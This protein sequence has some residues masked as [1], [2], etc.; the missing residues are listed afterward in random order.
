MANA[1]MPE[2]EANY[3]LIVI[4]A[5]P[6]GY[7][8][9]IRAAQQGK[10]VA[11]VEEAQ[12]GG[13]CLNWGCIPT[14]A[15]LKSAELYQKMQKAA[16]FGI[17]VSALSPDI[18][19]MVTRSKQVSEKLTAGIKHLMKKNRIT[20]LVG[21][22]KLHSSTEI[23]VQVEVQN[24]QHH[25]LYSANHVILA[26]G[27]SARHLPGIPPDGKHIWSYREALRQSRIPES[28]VVIGSGAIGIEFANFYHA[29]GTDVTVVE[30]MSQ[31]MP[32][33]DTEIA[34]LAMKTMQ[35]RGIKFCLNSKVGSVKTD[36]DANDI[37][38]NITN[39][40][41]EHKQLQAQHLLSA[42]GVSPNTDDLGLEQ[43]GIALDHKGFIAT[44]EFC[45]TNVAN[46]FAIGDV[47][48]A[49]CL[50]HKAS[51]EGLLVADLICGKPVHPIEKHAIPGCIYS[52]PQ[53]ASIGLTQAEAE[54]QSLPIK[55][56]RFS[57]AGNGK[58]I[59]QGES[60]G[61]VKVIFHQQTGELLGAH[62]VGSEVT[63]MLQGFA[64]GKTLETTEEQLMQTIFPH[65]TM[66]EMMHESVLDAFDQ[67]I[68]A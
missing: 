31:I 17:R 60:D 3:D 19:T 59:A 13:I 43:C 68:H 46:V 23:Q 44:D 36:G 32:S 66:S 7:V 50:A 56:G 27:A 9:A 29:L 65:P 35:K 42:V 57:A 26:T 2:T 49:P 15:L 51:H 4:G 53:V 30:M 47:A 39:R 18:D 34:E 38:V 33:E 6:G 58:A 48:G 28:L 62:L 61:L 21:R 8:A 52:Y 40:D 67:A 54:Q 11:I 16:D 63:E 20:V 37:T 64:I 12:L 45:R 22:G 24:E 41:G 1:N 25:Q 10:N 14:K 55:V 5:G